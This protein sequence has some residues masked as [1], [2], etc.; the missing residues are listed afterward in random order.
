MR[1]A[2]QRFITFNGHLLWMIPLVI[3]LGVCIRNPLIIA[4]IVLMELFSLGLHQ[5]AHH[6]RIYFGKLWVLVLLGVA[7]MATILFSYV[8]GW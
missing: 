7:T 8:K 3:G 1:K 5:Y 2:L 6:E 4:A